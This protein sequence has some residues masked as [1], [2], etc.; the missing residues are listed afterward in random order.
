MSRLGRSQA[1]KSTQ[2]LWG[3]SVGFEVGWCLGPSTGWI[4]PSGLTSRAW[5]GQAENPSKPRGTFFQSSQ[6]TF[7]SSPAEPHWC[8]GARL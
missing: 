7:N 8:G 1:E 4:L 5:M 2:A 3:Q 6:V